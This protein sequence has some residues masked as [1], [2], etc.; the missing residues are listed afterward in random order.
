[1]NRSRILGILLVI[2]FSVLAVVTLSASTFQTLGPASGR[3]D[4][5]AAA[6]IPF[7]VPTTLP[8][9][10]NQVSFAIKIPQLLPPNSIQGQTF[11][12]NDHTAVILLYQNT[13]MVTI[14]SPLSST[15]FAVEVFEQQ[16]SQNPILGVEQPP[17]PIV[18]SVQ[19][20]GGP[21]TT[22]TTMQ[23][24]PGGGP[25]TVCG[26]AGWGAS[27]N[28]GNPATLAWWSNG[29]VYTLTANASMSTLLD[30]GNSMC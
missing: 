28:A 20:D 14:E 30:I 2:M 7:A 8:Y 10:Q 4:I 9:A 1:M 24:I 17:A 12:S 3:G 29:V 27:G 11:L 23:Q 22:V 5:P 26:V 19:T 6:P 25:Y 21:V 16:A 18:I 15:G 13:G